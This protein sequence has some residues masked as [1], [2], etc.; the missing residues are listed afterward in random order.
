MAVDPV[1]KTNSIEADLAPVAQA[2][3]APCEI[4]RLDAASRDKAETV[5]AIPD[6]VAQGD[7]GFA[8]FAGQQRREK[9]AIVSG[10]RFGAD[11]GDGEAAWRARRELLTELHARHAAADN[12]KPFG[13][14]A[15]DRRHAAASSP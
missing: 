12:E 5:R 11:D 4:E 6:F 3:G 8:D 2:R 10:P 14:V 9:H 13:G 7:V 1:A 15:A